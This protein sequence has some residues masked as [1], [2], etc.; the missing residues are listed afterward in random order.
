MK[1]SFSSPSNQNSFQKKIIFDKLA[2]IKD[3][4]RKGIFKKDLSTIKRWEEEEGSSNMFILQNSPSDTSLPFLGVLNGMFQREG[5]AV[6]DYP[7]GDK[8]FGYYS[9]DERNKHGLYAYS[10]LFDQKKKKLNS[11]FYFGLWLD[12]LK[13]NHGIYLWLS[14]DKNTEPFSDFESADFQAYVGN[15]EADNFTKGTLMTKKNGKYYVYHGNFSKDGKKEGVGC[16][17]FSAEKEQLLYGK[18]IE[19]NFVEGF[20]GKFD[21]DGNMTNII[22]NYNGNVSSCNS[23]DENEFK[24]ICQVMFNFRNIIMSKDYFGEL[25]DE[26]GRVIDFRD[27]VMTDIDVLNSEQYI[28]I[29]KAT[30]AYNKCTIFKDIEKVIEGN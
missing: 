12:D 5:Y 24:K 19:D 3:L 20:V 26:F 27:T 14:E 25:Y 29:M 7:N 10:P 11:E 9:E 23:I 13:D 1:P 22:Q 4:E 21:D 30:I 8:Y 6:N 17:Y 16:F 2:I 28:D 18:F 15:F